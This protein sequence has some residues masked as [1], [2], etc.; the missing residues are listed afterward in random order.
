MLIR[1]FCVTVLTCLAA[2]LFMGLMTQCA[3]LMNQDSTV[4]FLCGLVGCIFLTVGSISL[5]PTYFRV[6]KEWMDAG[7]KVVDEAKKTFPPKGGVYGGL[8]L[9]ALLPILGACSRI[10]VGHVGIIINQAG[11]NRGPDEIPVNTGWVSYNPFTESVVEYPTFV[12]TAV[13]TH[14]RTESSPTNEEVSFNSKEGLCVTGDLSLSYQLASY[15]VPHFYT[16]FR[17][18]DINAFTHGF[19][20]NVARD[21]FNEIG[22]KYAIDEIYGPKK[23]EFLA[24][25]RTKLNAEMEPYGITIEQFG[26]IG[27]PRPPQVVI[28]ALNA[29]VAATQEAM[30]VENEILQAKAQAQKRIAEAEGEA[31]ANRALAASVTPELLRWKQMEITQKA[32]DKWDGRRPTVEGS[33]SGLLMQIPMPNGQ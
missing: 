8:V 2:L 23:D 32:I 16:K 14:D 13:W 30:R 7:K 6:A 3:H 22:G 12:Q 21:L 24:Q 29:K 31:A 4:L 9:L 19:M 27:A 10:G 20:R 26:F 25:V 5:I 18:D 17:A 11:D 15:K 33:S 1:G 28:D